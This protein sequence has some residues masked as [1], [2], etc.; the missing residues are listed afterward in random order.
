MCAVTCVTCCLPSCRC[1][2]RRCILAY[3]PLLVACC[4]CQQVRK[5]ATYICVVVYG[6]RHISWLAV[7]V[8]RQ[9]HFWC[10][11][12][13]HQVTLY[14]LVPYLMLTLADRPLCVLPPFHIQLPA[15]LMVKHP[16]QVL[17]ACCLQA[18]LLMCWG[19]H[20]QVLR[21]AAHPQPATDVAGQPCCFMS[22]L[23]T[24]SSQSLSTGPVHTSSAD[25]ATSACCSSAT[26]AA[27][28]PASAAAS[29]S[30]YAV[31]NW[32]GPKLLQQQQTTILSEQQ[33]LT[34]LQ[35]AADGIPFSRLT[36][37]RHTRQ[38]I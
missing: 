17:P 15:L 32:S 34:A 31:V 16:A 26:G 3:I 5:P 25:V 37:T 7:G 38:N 29:S 20:H 1:T 21:V 33:V 11:N 10:T 18:Q 2:S 19:C 30:I 6:S 12:C 24:L 9:Q 4:A 23:C 14:V 35:G 28:A 13:N 36:V 27:S 8:L 22:S